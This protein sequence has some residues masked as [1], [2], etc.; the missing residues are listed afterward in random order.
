MA[1]R[2]GGGGASGG[3]GRRR[4]LW[5]GGGGVGEAGG[6]YRYRRGMMQGTEGAEQETMEETAGTATEVGRRRQTTEDPPA[7]KRDNGAGGE[8][9]VEISG[10]EESVDKTA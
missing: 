3:V 1:A 4:S 2:A 10:T 8:Y 9:R 7:R 6:R 5:D